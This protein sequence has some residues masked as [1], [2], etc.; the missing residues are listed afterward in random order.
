VPGLSSRLR[1]RPAERPESGLPHRPFYAVVASAFP[2]FGEED[3]PR[4]HRGSGT[5]F[6]A[7]CNL[8]CVFCQNYE[9]VQADK[10]AVEVNDGL[11][12]M[13]R[14]SEVN[15]QLLDLNEVARRRCSLSPPSICG[16]AA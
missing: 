16:G 13:L 3:C 2:H 6:F 9:I 10:R 14:R 8:K 4:G 12:S 15:F 7:N 11:R 1:R 5:I